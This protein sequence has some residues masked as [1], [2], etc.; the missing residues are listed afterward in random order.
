MQ[1]IKDIYV[2]DDDDEKNLNITTND[3]ADIQKKNF[4]NKKSK[5]ILFNAEKNNYNN[6]N[7][8]FKANKTNL[9]NAELKTERKFLNNKISY[10]V[11]CVFTAYSQNN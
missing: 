1:I 3:L 7:N 10:L 9:F 11:D 2:D 8:Q 4:D 5:K 6:E